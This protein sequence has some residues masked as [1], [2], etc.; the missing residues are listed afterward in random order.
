MIWM[1]IP[2]PDLDF[3]PISDAGVKKGTEFRFLIPGPDPLHWIK[4]MLYSTYLSFADYN[5]LLL[6]SL[7]NT[8]SSAAPQI[9]LCRKILGSNPVLL[10]IWH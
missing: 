2:D 6:C 7:F 9:S 10:R 4:Y 8:V 1:F 5:F 3:L